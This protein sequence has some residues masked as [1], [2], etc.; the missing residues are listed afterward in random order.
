MH[1]VRNKFIIKPELVEEDRNVPGDQR[2][3]DL[4]VQVANSIVKVTTKHLN[5]MVPILDL[6]VGVVDGRLT[7]QLYRK[8]VANIL[9]L[10][11]RSAMSARQK[12]V[13]LTL[14]VVGI[15]RNTK[16]D[17][18]DRIKNSFLSEFSL[19]MKESGYSEMSRFKVISSGAGYEKQL[20]RAEAGTCP[21]YC[22][23]GYMAEERSRK[24]QTSKKSWYKP[25]STVLFCPP[26]PN[27]QLAAGLRR[28]VDEET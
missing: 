15:L 3:A 9:V 4:V 12:R 11:E 21:L 1:Y 28:I 22:P 25:F 18:P 17:L 14:E 7:W 8:E 26:T 20:A 5:Q 13:S 2:T 6:Q 23:K 16:C 24:K 27:S 19:R 10:M